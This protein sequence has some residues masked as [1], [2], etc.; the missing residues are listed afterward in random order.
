MCF[1]LF[2]KQ[3]ALIVY[4]FKVFPDSEELFVSFV[5]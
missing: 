4:S 3:T 2:S 1:A 5:I